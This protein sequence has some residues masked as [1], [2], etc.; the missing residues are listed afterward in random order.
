MANLS[1]TS[2]PTPQCDSMSRSRHRIARASRGRR[3]DGGG[4]G[5]LGRRGETRKTWTTRGAG[6]FLFS[7]YLSLQSRRGGSHRRKHVRARRRQVGPGIRSVQGFLGRRASMPTTAQFYGAGVGGRVPAPACLDRSIRYLMRA[8][9]IPLSPFLC[10]KSCPVFLGF[11]S[12]FLLC[13][14]LES[15]P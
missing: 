2:W 7:L 15:R 10:Q 12:V 6:V 9:V 11:S 5:R 1:V 3:E 13:K 8:P 14:G 4:R